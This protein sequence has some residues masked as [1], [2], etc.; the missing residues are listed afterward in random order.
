M[1]TASFDGGCIAQTPGFPAP[2]KKEFDSIKTSLRKATNV[3]DPP[4]TP[5]A[6]KEI[7]ESPVG[8]FGHT[9]SSY[10]RVTSGNRASRR[11]SH[12]KDKL[13]S[14]RKNIED[15]IS[16]IRDSFGSP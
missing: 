11:D 15:K 13:N 9:P 14:I 5:K 1:A 3:E 6:T 10:K 8:T 2:E 16:S 12:S 4:E 7:N